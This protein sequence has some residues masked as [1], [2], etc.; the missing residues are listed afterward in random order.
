MQVCR[1][2]K[3]LGCVQVF[4]VCESLYLSNYTSFILSVTGDSLCL[5]QTSEGKYDFKAYLKI[6][7]FSNFVFQNHF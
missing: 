2:W 1:V 5:V 4:R 6:D 7:F 3:C